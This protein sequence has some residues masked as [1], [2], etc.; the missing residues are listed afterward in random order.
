MREVLP[1]DSMLSEIV[2]GVI[3]RSVTI[4]RAAPGAGKTTRV[5]PALAEKLSG[6][7]LLVEPR[8]VAARGAAERIAAERNEVCGEKTGFIVRGERCCQRSARV[9]AVTN[10]IFLNMIINDPELSGVDAVIFDEFHERSM[11]SDLGFTLALES[12]KLFSPD[13]KIVIMSAT[14]DEK[15]L[16]AIVPEAV[17]FDVPGRVYPLEIE[18]NSDSIN[19]GNIVKTTVSGVIYAS[20]RH[21]GNILVFLP[22]TAEIS[23]TRAALEEFAAANSIILQELHGRMKLEEQNQIL[24]FSGDKRRII[25]ATNIAESSVTIPGITAVVDCGFEKRLFHNAATGFDKLETVRISFESADQR[26]GRA[27]RTA[28]GFVYRLWSS[29]DSKAFIP[30]TRAE[31]SSCD[32]AKCALTLADWGCHEQ[33]VNWVTPPDAARM[34]A[35]RRL[36]QNLGAVDENGNITPKGRKISALPVHP[37]TGAVL[38]SA[39]NNS[40]LSLACETAAALE[41]GLPAGKVMPVSEII[42]AMRRKERS[43]RRH[44]ELS[45]DL[46]RMMHAESDDSIPPENCSAFI[47]AAYPDRIAACNGNIYR[48]SGGSSAVMP[49]DSPDNGTP[50]AACGEVTSSGNNSVIR[51]WEKTGINEI[52]ELFEHEIKVV[53][54][55]AFD[56]VSGKVTARREEKLGELVLASSPCPADRIGSAK[57][58][59]EEA[60]RRHIA[61]P[62]EKNSPALRLKERVCFASRQGDQRFPDWGNDEVW[63]NFLLDNLPE[64]AKINSFSALENADILPL[65]Q[66]FLGWELS[67]ELDRSC[68]AK[69]VTPAGSSRFIDY[70][71]DMPTLSVKVQEMFGVK[72]H[73]CVGKNRIPLKIDLLSPAMRSVQITSDLPRFWQSSWQLVRKDMKSRYP[74]HDWPEDPSNAT[75]HTKVR[76]DK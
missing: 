44:F 30:H 39:G 4:L 69:F 59:I 33:E 38:V 27:G 26:A 11:Q 46:L 57:A 22:G 48:F 52:K 17:F 62:A 3:S 31:I 76:I 60:F 18:Y 28:P 35:A 53:T 61:V 47:L 50:F 43:F 1:I 63:K 21:S 10:G 64:R 19:A 29:S 70:S 73:P 9:I 24:R 72:I 14:I 16:G 40:E 42:R 15:K 66:E 74:K 45:R 68:P 37:R 23:Q 12:R 7:I 67:N 56:P 32:L 20:R 41:E 58:V 54:T 49:P 2:S 34:A 65:M 71:Q 13:L 36:L 75:A 51:L 55:A 6:K 5:A 25:L 8:R